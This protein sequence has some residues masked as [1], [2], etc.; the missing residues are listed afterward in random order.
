V[1]LDYRSLKLQYLFTAQKVQK[2]QCLVSVLAKMGNDSVLK[3]NKT[4]QKKSPSCL[5]NTVRDDEFLDNTHW[6]WTECFLWV[7]WLGRTHEKTR[8][9]RKHPT[10][11]MKQS[12][13]TFWAQIQF[14]TM[15]LGSIIDPNKHS[16]AFISKGAYSLRRLALFVGARFKFQSTGSHR[17]TIFNLVISFL[18]DC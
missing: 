17:F 2:V 8:Q 14:L 16:I 13:I 3:Q 4:E 5:P 11:H 18:T 7:H 12:S 6:I 10:E 15:L 1:F 9:Q